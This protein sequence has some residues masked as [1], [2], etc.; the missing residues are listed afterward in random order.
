M[1]RHLHRA[2]QPY[3]MQNAMELR[4]SCLI[5]ATLETSFTLRGLSNIGYPPTSPNIA[6]ATKM[7]LMIDPRNI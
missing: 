3:G 4:H 2:E 7:N 1:K 6:P 5:V